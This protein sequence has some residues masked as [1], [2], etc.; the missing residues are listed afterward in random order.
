M[1][2]EATLWGL[3]EHF[4]TGGLDAAR[5]TTAKGAVMIFPYPAGILQGDAIWHRLK[6]GSKWR[7]VEMSE[8]NFTRQGDIAVLAYRAS[9]EKTDATLYRALCAS[10]YLQDDGKWL[11]M[12]HQQT[13]V[14]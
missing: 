3:E 8:R 11:R 1:E 5:A 9:G 12:S 2:E 6:T 10:T 4:W 13:P 14:S 7:S